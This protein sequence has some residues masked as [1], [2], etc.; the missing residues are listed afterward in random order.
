V[1]RDHRTAAPVDA[2]DPIEVGVAKREFGAPD[3][4]ARRTRSPG[5]LDFGNRE[6]TV[7]TLGVEL[8]PGARLDQFQHG[9][10]LDG[11]DHRHGFIHVELLEGAMLDRDF[12]RRFVDLDYRPSTNAV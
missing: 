7:D 8:H 11:V 6:L 9:R 12:L 2:L 3:A 10:I 5:L 1:L 4:A